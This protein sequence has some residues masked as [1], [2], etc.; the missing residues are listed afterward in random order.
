[1]PRA[2]LLAPLLILSVA[3][4]AAAILACATSI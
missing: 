2:H 3:L 4:S 1:M